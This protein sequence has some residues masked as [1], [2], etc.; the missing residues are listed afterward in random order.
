MEG[1]E[2]IKKVVTGVTA[3]LALIEAAIEK[4]ADAIIVHHGYFWKGEPQ[5]IV[6][7][8]Y[9]RL[10][11]LIKNDINLYG[12]H[13]P[14]DANLDAGNNCG[15]ANALGLNDLS[16]LESGKPLSESIG[17]FGLLSVPIEPQM[18]K[19]LVANVVGREVLF[20]Q[21][22][23][24]MISKVG[25]CTGGA[26]GYIS[27]AIAGQADVF[28]TGEVSEQTIHV[29]REEGIHF[30]AAGHHA[31]ECFGPKLLAEYISRE[32]GLDCEFIDIPN[33]A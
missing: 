29:A 9:R 27:K 23:E 28:I 24:R 7:M 18:F 21:V 25:I 19:S 8:K 11:K 26:Q 12:F 14:M 30:C 10:S 4:G 22:S 1:K 3:S 15:L 17:L 5:E 32:W 6:G 31:T 2:E 20:E 33:P 16:P 13:L